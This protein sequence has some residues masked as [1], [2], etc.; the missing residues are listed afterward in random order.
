VPQRYQFGSL[1]CLK[2]KNGPDVWAFRFYDRDGHRPQLLVGTVEKYPTESDAQ[3]AVEGRR[4]MLNAASDSALFHSATVSG[5]ADRFM[6]EY[7][8]KKCSQNTRASY[9]GIIDNHIRPRWGDKY[10]HQVR[11]MQVEAWFD[12]YVQYEIVEN[13]KDGKATT[14]TKPVSSSVRSHIRNLMHTMFERAV[15]WEIVEKNP[16][17]LVH[18]SQKRLKKPRVLAADQL[19]GM[20]PCLAEPYR[21]MVIIHACLGLRSCE[22]VALQWSDID[23]GSL[24]V[25]IQRSF[26]R[27]ELKAVKTPASEATL[28]LDPDLATILL[29]HK[30]R[31]Q[32]TAPQDFVFANKGGGIRWPESMLQDHIKPAAKQA[33]IGSV[34]WHTF[35]HT[36]STLLHDAGTELAVQKDLLR[37]ANILTT[38]NVYTQAVP[39]KLRQA[40]SAAVK[41]LLR[42]SQ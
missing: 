33:G 16:I 14:T 36:Y 5:L 17:D 30:S 11:P 4:M 13:G 24:S 19:M 15:F 26:V 6:L 23:F 28:P 22:T 41:T 2:R 8:H 42:S 31:S 27:G 25:T 37:H 32:H 7:A 40:N 20:V 21:T 1:Q 9:Q 18:Q 29:E 3:R 34:G 35:R 12:T 38:M 39:A 10:V